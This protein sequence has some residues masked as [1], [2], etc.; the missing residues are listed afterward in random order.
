MDIVIRRLTYADI[1]AGLRLGAQN[2]WNQRDADWRRQLDLEPEACFAAEAD[3]QVVG[4]ACAC[5]FEHVAWVNLVL[6]DQMWRGKGIG[7]RLMRY[8]LAYL[9]ERGIPSIRLDA[10]PLGQP[11]YEKLGFKVEYTLTRYDG[12]GAVKPPWAPEIEV[13]RHSDLSDIAELDRA[14]TGT[15][16]AKL[17]HHLLGARD[18]KLLVARRANTLAGYAG[19]RPGAHAWQIGPCMGGPT[20]CIMLLHTIMLFVGQRTFIDVP[21]GLEESNA[22]VVGLG[23]KRQRTLTRM[24]RGPR[25]HEDL[26][27]MWCSFGPEKG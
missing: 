26:K 25:I 17:L 16:R 14:I 27:R 19:Y 7:T 12:T 5:V 15:P 21:Q 18:G 23:L 20:E 6:V 9:D 8:V 4:T 22:V 2:G 10:T 24:G 1:D 3:G 13:A 11:V